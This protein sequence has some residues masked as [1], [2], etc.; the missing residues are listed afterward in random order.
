MKRKTASAPAHT[1]NPACPGQ[2]GGI[3]TEAD[4]REAFD[5][6]RAELEDGLRR[7]L[8]SGKRW[9]AGRRPGWWWDFHEAAG[10]W[11]QDP[12]RWER[13]EDLA[14]FAA[15]RAA[16][17]AP[18]AAGERP[19]WREPTN[20]FA[21]AR[22]LA[23]RGLLERWEVEVLLERAEQGGEFAHQQARAVREGLALAR[24]RTGTIPAK[25]A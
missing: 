6:H 2:P 4:R 13:P 11:R 24:S 10:E 5:H 19:A 15:R 14:Y 7:Q 3:V 1:C 17:S 22:F 16:V 25:E 9:A 8:Q 20:G 18:D 12:T 21:Q 23:A